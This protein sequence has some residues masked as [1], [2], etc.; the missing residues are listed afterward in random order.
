MPQNPYRTALGWIATI[1]LVG[2]AVI[3]LVAGLAGSSSPSTA[4]VTA[5]FIGGGLAG[6]GASVLLFWLLACA[7]TYRQPAMPSASSDEDRS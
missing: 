2:G 7:I 3:V 4:T 6:F 1:G 5:G